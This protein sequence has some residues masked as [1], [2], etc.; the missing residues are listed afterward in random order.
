MNRIDEFARL[1][2]AELMLL[3]HM[4]MRQ[5]ELDAGD[6]VAFVI[7]IQ[8]E[9]TRLLHIHALGQGVDMPISPHLITAAGRWLQTLFAGLRA[10]GKS[11]H[12]DDDPR[13]LGCFEIDEAEQVANEVDTCRYL[14]G[15]ER[16]WSLVAID[17]ELPSREED[18]VPPDEVATALKDLM[19]YVGGWDEKPGH[20]CGNAADVLRRMEKHGQLPKENDDA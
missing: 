20:P 2:A 18:P 3:A 7:E 13:E 4:K 8:K 17:A 19:H 6:Y 9:C 14:L 12:P 11:Y 5:L 15:E 1:P 10:Q 16:F